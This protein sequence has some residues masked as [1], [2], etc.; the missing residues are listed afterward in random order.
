MIV[1][2]LDRAARNR[3]GQLCRAFEADFSAPACSQVED[4]PVPPSNLLMNPGDCCSM[5][6][7]G[8]WRR[9]CAVRCSRSNGAEIG[10]VP[11]DFCLDVG[12]C[13]VDNSLEQDWRSFQHFLVA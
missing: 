8:G 1:P 6:V 4:G 9:Q 5:I 7:S 12:C 3:C 13:A 11:G 2:I 10:V